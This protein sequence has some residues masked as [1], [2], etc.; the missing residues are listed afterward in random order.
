MLSDHLHGQQPLV[1]QC[2]S[3]NAD[4]QELTY[5]HYFAT[6]GF[7]DKR[8]LLQHPDAGHRL[9]MSGLSCNA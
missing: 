8:F 2:R 6:S 5:L 1:D 3:S 7:L 4:K 9:I